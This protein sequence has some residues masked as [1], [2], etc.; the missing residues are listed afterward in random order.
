MTLDR[1]GFLKSSAAILGTSIASKTN[2]QAETKANNL[3]NKLSPRPIVISTWNFALEANKP[4][5]NIIAKGGTAL[6]AVEMGARIPEADENNHSVG[7]GGFPDREGI[8][9]LDASIMDHNII[10]YG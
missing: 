7:Y 9:T 10:I 5:W 8:V 4:A 2:A 6:D 1:R 3:T